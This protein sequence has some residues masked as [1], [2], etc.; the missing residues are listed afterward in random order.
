MVRYIYECLGGLF[1]ISLI[2]GNVHSNLKCSERRKRG[3]IR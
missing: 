2:K 3:K 1:N